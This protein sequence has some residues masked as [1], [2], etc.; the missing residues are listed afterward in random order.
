MLN[1]L[2]VDVIVIRGASNEAVGTLMLVFF[3]FYFFFSAKSV[4]AAKT[5]RPRNT[6]LNKLVANYTCYS[7]NKHKPIRPDSG[8]ILALSLFGQ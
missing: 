6:K 8:A 5:V 4:W 3:F 1:V 2:L 7:G